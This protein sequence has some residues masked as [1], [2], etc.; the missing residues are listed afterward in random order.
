MDTFI[1]ILEFSISPI[2]V[3]LGVVVSKYF[4]NKK[5][6]T[7]GQ[8]KAMLDCQAKQKQNLDQAKVDFSKRLDDVNSKLDEVNTQI[9]DIVIA[10]TK[11][12]DSVHNL[13]TETRKH[14]QVIERTFKLEE[15]CSVLENRE[16]VS[17]NRLSDLERHEEQKQI[18]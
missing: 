17:E 18:K 6:K 14:N 1:K 9:S 12:F 11:L 2:M 3:F 7:D 4:D 15:R 8:S 5:G 10:N 16:K 13:E